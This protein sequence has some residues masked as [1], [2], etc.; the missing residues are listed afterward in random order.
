MERRMPRLHPVPVVILSMAAL[1]PGLVSAKDKSS[2]WN[3]SFAKYTE[4][5]GA[6]RVGADTC[7][8]C[9]AGIAK[10]FR[11]AFHAQQGVEC[12]DCHGPGSLHVNGNGDLISQGTCESGAPPTCF[13]PVM[14][15]AAL[16]KLG[17]SATQIS[18]VIVPQWIGQS[19][20]YYLFPYKLEGGLIFNFGSYRDYWNPNL[21]GV[22][23][24]FNVYLRRSW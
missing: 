21:N 18:E 2:P 22:L 14:F 13:D 3:G 1:S 6:S 7:T 15:Q 9:H 20:A 12:E 19:R 17:F 8:T 4:I 11:H 16:D 24:T 5:P 10:G 23:R